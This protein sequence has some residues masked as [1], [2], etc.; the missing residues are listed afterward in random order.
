[1]P[2][3]RAGPLALESE[4]L[5]LD[6][7]PVQGRLVDGDTRIV[8][9]KENREGNGPHRD[10]AAEFRHETGQLLI[11]QRCHVEQLVLIVQ[12]RVERVS[13]KNPDE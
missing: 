8:S 13:R 12:G 2:P 1:M 7:G 5:S 9:A 6:V 11:E 10:V 4:E 3:E